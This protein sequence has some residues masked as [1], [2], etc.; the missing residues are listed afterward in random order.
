MWYLCHELIATLSQAKV[1]DALSWIYILE[2]LSIGGHGLRN[3]GVGQ[4]WDHSDRGIG[5][6]EIIHLEEGLGY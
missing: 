3:S 2:D 5:I 1:K 4:I 6:Q